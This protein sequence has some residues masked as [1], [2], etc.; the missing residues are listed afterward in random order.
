[1]A[2]DGEYVRWINS[3]EPGKLMFVITTI[4]G[5][6]SALRNDAQK[7]RVHGKTVG[8]DLGIAGLQSGT[9]TEKQSPHKGVAS[10]PV[11]TTPATG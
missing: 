10:Q 5:Y 7:A 4:Q 11:P 9:Q 3:K 8:T 6:T 1:M 2:G